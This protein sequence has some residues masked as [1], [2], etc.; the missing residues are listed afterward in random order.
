M[1]S[2]GKLN[3]GLIASFCEPLTCK[4]RLGRCKASFALSLLR[5]IIFGNMGY[6]GAPIIYGASPLTFLFKRGGPI[7]ECVPKQRLWF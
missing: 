3:L 6:G 1:P 4:F 2:S 5:K 7:H